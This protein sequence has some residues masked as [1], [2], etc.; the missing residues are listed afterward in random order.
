VQDARRAG[1]GL[2]PQEQEWITRCIA[3]TKAVQD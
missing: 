1:R 3:V 2:L